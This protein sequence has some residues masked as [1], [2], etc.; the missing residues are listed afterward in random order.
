MNETVYT[1][2][3]KK[4][5]EEL[6]LFKGKVISETK[7][8]NENLSICK[9]MT[10]D[11]SKGNLFECKNEN[12]ARLKCAQTGRQVCGDCVSSLYLTYK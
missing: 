1:L 12:E 8:V 5:T 11:E 2:K 7:C 10:S 4:N 6:H 3:Q 9:K